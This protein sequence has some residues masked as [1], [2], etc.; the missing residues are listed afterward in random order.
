[1]TLGR[2]IDIEGG[3]VPGD[4]AAVTANALQGT[5]L[6]AQLASGQ[7]PLADT[8]I[9]IT[10]G[11]T[12]VKVAFDA[13]SADFAAVARSIQAQVRAG[14]GGNLPDFTARIVQSGG[15][16]YLAYFNWL[17]SE[18]GIWIHGDASTGALKFDGL[19]VELA[20]QIRATAIYDNGTIASAGTL[21]VDWNNGNSQRCAANLGNITIA[22]EQS[23]T[24]EGTSYT[25]QVTNISA[26][27]RTVTWTGV[28]SWVG[29]ASPTASVGAGNMTVV[30]IYVARDAAGGRYI[31]GSVILDNVTVPA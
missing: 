15:D 16:F 20:T 28:D 8:S 7:L 30:Q 9:E 5:D 6:V 23:S 26:S 4:I 10:A 17:G 24:Y 31:I 2:L 11:T 14:S 18:Q 25:M 19:Y 3:A 1:M 22:L 12:T 29:G 27:A 13:N 21:N